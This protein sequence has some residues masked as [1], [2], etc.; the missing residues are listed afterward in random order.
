MRLFKFTYFC[1]PTK[2]FHS[3]CLARK[4][5]PKKNRNKQRKIRETNHFHTSKSP[6]METEYSRASVAAFHPSLEATAPLEA[7]Q[8][9]A[10]GM[11]LSC[12]TGDATKLPRPLPS[13]LCCYAAGESRFPATAALGHHNKPIQ[14][15]TL[16]YHIF[17]LTTNFANAALW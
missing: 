1:W 13:L 15:V 9:P 11:H 14:N 2:K 4:E 6:R 10:L 16:L 7:S 8:S 3:W 12:G 17:K 5:G